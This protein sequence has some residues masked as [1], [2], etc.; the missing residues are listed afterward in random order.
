MP[1][2]RMVLGMRLAHQVLL[3]LLV[4]GEGTVSASFTK[5]EGLG[6]YLG[7][8]P[9]LGKWSFVSATESSS[10][11][12][13]SSPPSFG[14]DASATASLWVKLPAGWEMFIGEYGELC[15]FGLVLFSADTVLESFTISGIE[16]D[17]KGHSVVNFETL[18]HEMCYVV[19]FLCIA[20]AAAATCDAFPHFPFP[21]VATAAVL[22]GT[23]LDGKTEGKRIFKALFLLVCYLCDPQVLAQDILQLRF[24]TRPCTWKA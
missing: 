3:F 2:F 22:H 9:I 14:D 8:V 19:G 24:S 17:S 4:F 23:T 1:C 18:V 10:L 5:F 16:T 21:A 12:K 7:N 15:E 13:P 11:L 20:E 6:K